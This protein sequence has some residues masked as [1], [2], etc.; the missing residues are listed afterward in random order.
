MFP[1]SKPARDSHHLR[2][3]RQMPSVVSGQSPC[4]AHHLIGHGMGGMGTKASDYLT[5]PL[6]RVEHTELHNMGWRSWEDIHGSQWRFVALTLEQ[7]LLD[8]DAPINAG[9][10]A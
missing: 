7:R 5:F 9:G 1:K 8:Q 10:T 4:D 6:T 3:V 2:W